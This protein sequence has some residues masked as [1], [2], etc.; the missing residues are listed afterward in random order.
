MLEGCHFTKNQLGI[1]IMGV[2]KSSFGKAGEYVGLLTK[3]IVEIEFGLSPQF[4][5]F[6]LKFP[7]SREGAGCQVRWWVVL[8]PRCLASGTFYGQFGVN[9][10]QPD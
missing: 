8:A 5:S 1:Q 10:A 3:K 7:P 2:P 4:S 9:T 6:F